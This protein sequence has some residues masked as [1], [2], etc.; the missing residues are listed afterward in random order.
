MVR[1]K[2]WDILAPKAGSALCGT[3]IL[4]EY[5]SRRN[6]LSLFVLPKALGTFI[7]PTPTE[8]NIA[9]EVIAFS[10]SFAVLI[11]YARLQPSKLRGL[12]GKGLSYMV[13]H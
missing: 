7:D 8:S 9:T 2:F 10:L 6:E 13:K 3:S 5:P 4:L 1:T 11:A 12:V